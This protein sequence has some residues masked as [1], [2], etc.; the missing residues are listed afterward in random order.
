MTEISVESRME[1][2]A[3]EPVA[4]MLTLSP[5]CCSVM[6]QIGILN[7]SPYVLAKAT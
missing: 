6:E 1:E 3:F 5:T 2:K 4:G 7:L